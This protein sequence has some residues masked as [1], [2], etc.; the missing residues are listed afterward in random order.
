VERI[1]VRQTTWARYGLGLLEQVE[2]PVEKKNERQGSSFKTK[3]RRSA[4]RARRAH[5][6]DVEPRPAGI[7]IIAPK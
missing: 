7:R 3:L 2:P 1:I 5:W 6:R 4:R